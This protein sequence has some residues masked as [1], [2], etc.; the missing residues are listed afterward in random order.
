M[1]L[2]FPNVS[3]GQIAKLVK[4]GIQLI[5]TVCSL[6]CQMLR[7]KIYVCKYIKISNRS[8]AQIIFIAS[9]AGNGGFNKD[10]MFVSV[11]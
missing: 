4:F 5:I 1:W 11:K 8:Y 7:Q 2:A 10:P 6:L 3:L 9:E